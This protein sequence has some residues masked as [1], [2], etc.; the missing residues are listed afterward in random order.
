MDQFTSSNFSRNNK[1]NVNNKAEVQ[2]WAQKFGVSEMK[3]LTVIF[4]IGPLV[5]NVERI[6]QLMQEHSI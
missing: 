2:Y 4:Q 3:L 1:I 5:K 6:L